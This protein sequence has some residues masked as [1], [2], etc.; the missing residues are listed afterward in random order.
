M[1]EQK[2]VEMTN[3]TTP[4]L[5]LIQNEL[6]IPK[7]NFNKFGDFKYRTGE[8]IMYAVKPLL[9]K[10]NAKL[11]TIEDVRQIGER[12]YFVETVKFTAPD[13]PNGISV[14]CWR[15]EADKGKQMSE[16]QNSGSTASY[17]L[18]GALGLLFLISDKNDDP[19]RLEPTNNRQQYQQRTNTQQR[20]NTQQRTNTQ[21][22][23]PKTS[24]TS[25]ELDNYLVQVNGARTRL[26]EIFEL[27]RSGNI[28]ASDWLRG[29]HTTQDAGAIKALSQ[30]YKAKDN[31]TQQLN[32]ANQQNS[33]PLPANSVF[34][35]T[36]AQA[37]SDTSGKNVFD[38]LTD[39]AK[40]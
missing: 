21:Q 3:N 2:Q 29:A 1:T 35:D 33:T 26:K 32:Q 11:Y 9:K 25:Q 30:L 8:D 23:Q 27:A 5:T 7:E 40:N 13:E 22:V 39:L 37:N 14:S 10:Y 24:F 4:V 6:N 17:A 31:A 20:A 28:R 16:S 12:Y 15:R 36:T 18:K 38:T 34:S 19:D